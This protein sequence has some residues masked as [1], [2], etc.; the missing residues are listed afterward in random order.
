MN[1]KIKKLEVKKDERGFLAEIIS[2]NERDK[3][4][5]L[6]LITTA[7]PTM[8]KGNH[9]H[10]RKTEWY[11]VV[12]GKGLLKVWR[13]NEKKEMEL[14]EKNPVLV[15]IPKNYFHS[16]TNI[17]NSEMYLMA[18]VSEPFNKEDPDTYYE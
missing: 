2:S 5:G 12:K 11:C 9:Y 3:R 7:H 1:L 8:T 16:I 15:E 4:L 17:G 6:V 14:S 18:V 13:K 10:K